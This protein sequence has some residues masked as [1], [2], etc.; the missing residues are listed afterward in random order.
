MGPSCGGSST[1]AEQLPTA[2]D[3]READ[4]F[5]ASIAKIRKSSA[6]RF[7]CSFVNLVVMEPRELLIEIV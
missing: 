4:P 2:S 6:P 7:C 5:P 1:A 3:M